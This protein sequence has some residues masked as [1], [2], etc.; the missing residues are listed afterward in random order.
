CQST[1]AERR[2]SLGSVSNQAASTITAPMRW[3]RIT[4]S[5]DSYGPMPYADFSAMARNSMAF[6]ASVN[7]RKRAISASV[8]RLRTLFGNGQP[9]VRDALVEVAEH[10]AQDLGR[11][12]IEI[13]VRS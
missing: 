7:G 4:G 9:S 2:T 6:P 10:R 8:L 12:R 5:T 1:R 11:L 3:A 13:S